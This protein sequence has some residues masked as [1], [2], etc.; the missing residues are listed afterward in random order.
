[1]AERR[2]YVIT[3]AMML[4]LFLASIEMTVVATA[5]PTIVAQLGGLSI[6]AWV[7][8]AYMLASTTVIPIFGKLS[9]IYGRRPIYLG[10]MAVFLIG[11]VLCGQARTM[12][13]LVLF[14][15]LQGLGAGGLLPLAFTIIGDIFT[16]EQRA[17]IQG[18]FAGV[19]GVSSVIGPLLGGF[20][21][22]HANW[23]W[24]F[25]LNIGPGLIA[26]S[27]MVVAWQDVTPRSSGQVDFVGAG[28]LSGGIISLLLAMFELN[29][30]SGSRQTAFWALLIV[31]IL[32]FSIL[33]LAERRAQNPILPLSLFRDRLFSTA[34]GHAFFSGFGLFGS[35]S[36]VPF[37]VESVL[38]TSATVAGAA[39]TPQV[40]GWVI[41]SII[42]SRLLLHF[43]YRTL[44]LVGMTLLVGGSSM[45]V[46]QISTTM[47]YWLLAVSVGLMGLGMGLSVPPFLIAVQSSVP[48]QSL[49]IAT[50]TL[51]FSRNVG[52]AIGV[53]VMGVILALRLASG[54][55]GAGID[56]GSI[57]LSGLIERTAGP[58]VP[59]LETLRN[60]LATAMRSIFIAALLAA[61]AAWIITSFAPRERISTR[62]D[63]ARETES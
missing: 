60:S 4:S 1:M 20:L 56:P 16:F 7:F 12:R 33:V 61:I 46:A 13:Q 17:K 18:L 22:D 54:L 53:S 43:S 49:G 29:S 30:K 27:I 45:M 55:V 36:F 57:S 24:V 47:P 37:F 9:D 14:R 52:G 5:M 3:A 10:A 6:Y 34:T 15:A 23:R 44:A 58:V 38:G 19:W 2:L 21:V 42:G 41:A 8:S 35:A 62:R 26:A 40:M 31:S 63:A 50:A 48:R 28:L 25:Y 32:A 39:L 51:Q 11:S 59:N